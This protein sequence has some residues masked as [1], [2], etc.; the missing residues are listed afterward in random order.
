MS[1]VGS[2]PEIVFGMVDS[3][4]CK[5]LY[6]KLKGDIMHGHRHTH[7]HLTLLAHGKVK[8]TVNGEESN[9]SAPNMIFIHKDHLHEIVALED[10]TVAYCVHAVRD[11]DTGDIIDSIGIP[12]G[13]MIESLIKA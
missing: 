4:W 13:I 7:N 8:V 9:F 2:S 6:F 1:D 3:V 10:D 12:N 11:N 5:Q